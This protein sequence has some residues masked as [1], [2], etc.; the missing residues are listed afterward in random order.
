MCQALGSIDWMILD[1]GFA[2]DDHQ[3]GNEQVQSKLPGESFAF[4]DDWDL[5]LTLS[6][7][8]S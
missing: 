6:R 1:V 7:I 4:V 5:Q 2:L 8:L 3:I